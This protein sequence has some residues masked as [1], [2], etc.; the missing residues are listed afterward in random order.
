MKMIKK[1]LVEKLFKSIFL[2]M[3]GL[4]F[5]F[6][7]GSLFADIGIATY[8]PWTE[9]LTFLGGIAGFFVGWADEE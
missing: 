5:G 6:T 7:A 2:G 9:I 8:I 1:T 4:V 3:I